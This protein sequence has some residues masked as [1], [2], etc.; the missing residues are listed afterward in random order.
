MQNAATTPIS[1]SYGQG[2][3]TRGLLLIFAIA[4][5]LRLFMVLHFAKPPVS[6]M[7]WN[8]QVG[9]NLAA[10]HGFTASPRP[11][12]VPG[13]YRSPGYPAFL[14]VVY[15]VAGH[16]FRAVYITQAIID[17]FTAVLIALVAL[18]VSGTRAMFLTG[19]AYALY[20]Y[21]AVFCGELTQDILLVF[22]VTLALLLA[23]RARDGGRVLQF[24]TLGIAVGAAAI[25][26]PFLVLFLLICAVVLASAT[27]NRKRRVV[28]IALMTT[29]MAVTISPWMIRNYVIFHAFV[30]LSVGS[31]GE[32][33]F[34]LLDEIKG[35]EQ[36]T[37]GPFERHPEF[38]PE[39]YRSADVNQYLRDF[40]D[41]ERLIAIEHERTRLA[42]AE[43]RP[44]W[45]GYLYLVIR[46]IPRNWLTLHAV[47][48]PGWMLAFAEALSFL[49]LFLGIISMVILRRHWKP[50]LPL[51]ATVIGITL[52]YAP[53]TPEAR[54]TLP[55]RPEMMALIAIAASSW[56]SGWRG[57]KLRNSFWKL[58][59]WRHEFSSS[60]PPINPSQKK[61][62]LAPS[63]FCLPPRNYNAA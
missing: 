52:F 17:A 40:P 47:G 6:D 2:R 63:F 12:Y 15:K 25:V 32:N 56:T 35:G 49:V 16:S 62:R 4:F 57:F 53:Y 43:L 9:Q 55:A 10:G 23:I 61:G 30:P 20:P 29:A 42:L 33:L 45:R 18:L 58:R 28:G 39:K 5:L 3:L 37:I 54:Y 19:F 48:R 44:Q 59:K 46:H 41:G 51:Y 34:L 26:K 21:P 27:Y 14:A 7:W 60:R 8:D 38:W 24:L 22:S 11:P 1:A 31:T 13:V 36:A 50:L